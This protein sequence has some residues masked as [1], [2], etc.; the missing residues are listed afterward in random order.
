MNWV[1]LA[2]PVAKTVFA[3]ADL[4]QRKPPGPRILIYHQIGAGLGRQMEVTRDDFVRQLDWMQDYGEIVDLDTALDRRGQPGS[5]RLIALTFDDGYRDTYDR[6]FPLLK[7]RNLPFTLY[8]ATESI[9]TGTPLTPGGRA[10]PLTWDQISEMHESGLA[11][12]GAHTHTHVDM[13]EL[14]MPRIDEELGVSNSLIEQ[15][16]GVEPA[17]FAYPWGY[18]AEDADETVRSL[19]DSAVLGAGAPV[20]ADRSCHLINRVPVQ[21]SDGVF[22]FT[23]KALRGFWLED[24]VR[25]R[26]RSYVGP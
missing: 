23:K 12:I 14:T 17:S 13:R 6:A 20:T 24:R 9:E 15:R 5:D 25:R 1:D 18:W 19:Y 16:L 7:E 22:Y 4:L 2:R 8:L 11:T 26:L 3:A 10:D 21:L